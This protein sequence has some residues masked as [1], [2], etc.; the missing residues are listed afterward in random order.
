MELEL[1]L[2]MESFGQ[3]P[4]VPG[5]CGGLERHVC[6]WQT[7]GSSSVHG[8]KWTQMTTQDVHLNNSLPK[9]PFMAQI[10]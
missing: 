10:G 1:E 4:Q 8:V 3:N 6:G 5:C 7:L 9:Q 2:A